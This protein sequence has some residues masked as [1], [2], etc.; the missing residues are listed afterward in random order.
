MPLFNLTVFNLESHQ[1]ALLWREWRVREDTVNTAQYIHNMQ[2][3][4]IIKAVML[5]YNRTTAPF[6][7]ANSALLF[8]KSFIYLLL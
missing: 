7:R 2:L 3:K 1:G 4:Q 5:I 6:T 8:A